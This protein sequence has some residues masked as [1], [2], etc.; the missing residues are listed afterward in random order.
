VAVGPCKSTAAEANAAVRPNDVFN[1]NRL[2]DLSSHAFG[3]D[4]TDR[5]RAPARS[6]GHNHG[7][8]SRW[9]RLRLWL[10]RDGGER[11][12]TCCKVQKS[13]ARKVRCVHPERMALQPGLDWTTL[14]PPGF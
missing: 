12:S 5:I 10:A 7:D 1:D 6:E 14:R 8:G 11:G 9:I 4:P 3:H 13:T 2:A